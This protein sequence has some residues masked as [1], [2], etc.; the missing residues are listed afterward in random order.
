MEVHDVEL[1]AGSGCQLVRKSFT[2]CGR[3]GSTVRMH[4]LQG[5]RVQLPYVVSAGRTVYDSPFLG[6]SIDAVT[7]CRRHG[8]IVQKYTI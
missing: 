7:I 6:Q 5:H 1:N 2:M 4:R 8:N 3:R